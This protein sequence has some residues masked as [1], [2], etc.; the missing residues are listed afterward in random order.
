MNKVLIVTYY[1]PPGSGAGVQRWLKFSKYLPSFGYEPVILTVDPDYAAYPAIDNS[2]TDDISDE[3]KVFRTRATDW[4]SF[5]RRDKS[6]IPSAGFA[7]DETKGIKEKIIK[8]IRGN[9][10]IPDPR[11]GWNKYAFREACRLIETENIEILITTG[12]PHSTHL[13]GLNLRKRYREI[14]WIA[15]FRDPW[16]DIYYYN[17]FYPT[18]FSRILDRSYEKDILVS[19]DRIITVGT[20]LKKL[21]ALKTPGIESKISVITNGYDEEDFEVVK[22]FASDEFKISYIGTLSDS[23]PISEFLDAFSLFAL[24]GKKVRLRF[25]GTVSSSQKSLIRSKLPISSVDFMQYVDHKAA[26]KYMLESSVLLLIIPHHSSNRSIITGK[27]FEYLATGNPVLC[28]GPDDGDAAE[29]LKTTKHGL[30]AGYTDSERI[31]SILEN[32]YQSRHD[33][34]RPAPGEFS[35]RA[36]TEKLVMQF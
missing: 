22:Q 1:W 35:R 34:V 20:S 30:C 9:F 10:F 4:F 7:T 17:Q 5:Y 13:I 25:I 28:L 33:P 2:L 12:P 18:V 26:I 31:L 6:K 27:I 24:P 32:Y 23:Y 15:D 3:L 29:I 8:F 19:S 14:K 16:T 11:R 21:L 36:L